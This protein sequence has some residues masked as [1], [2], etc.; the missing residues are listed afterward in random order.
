MIGLANRK[1]GCDQELVESERVAYLRTLTAGIAHQINNLTAAILTAAQFALSA[2]NESEGERVFGRE[3]RPDLSTLF[4]HSQQTG[5]NRTRPASGRETDS[6]TSR[7]D[8]RQQPHFGWR[9]VRNSVASAQRGQWLT[10]R[11]PRTSPHSHPLLP[12]TR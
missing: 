11:R 1:P 9:T 3:S 5:R 7:N 8:L 12:H 10:A 6:R 4:H 2:T